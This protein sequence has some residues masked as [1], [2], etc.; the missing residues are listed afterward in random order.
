MDTV[1][2]HGRETA[3]TVTNGGESA[4]TICFVHGSGTSR[5]V[6]QFQ[7]PLSDRYDTVSLDL[8]GHGE[9]DEI[10]ANAG[11]AALSAYTDDLLAVVDET[12]STVLVGSSLGGAVVLHTLLERSFDPEAAVLTGTGARMG[13]LDD[14]LVWLESDFER[15]IEFLHGPDRLFHDPDPELLETSRDRMRE[16]GQQTTER[17][18]RTC[19]QFDVRNDLGNIDVPTLAVCGEYDQLT[20]PW[21]HEY[22]ADE[23]PNG[24]HATIDDAAHLPMLEQPDTF[25]GQL[26]DFL[27]SR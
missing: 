15:A 6:W 20:P 27:E 5:E 13:V 26:I 18:F 4:E 19:H 3:Y 14:L 25:N 10:Q 7:E 21:F 22:L 2:H 12:D 23:I 16:C 8:S 11:Y 9:S 17:D 24:V 1:T